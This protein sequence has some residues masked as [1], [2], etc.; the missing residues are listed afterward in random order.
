MRVIN[1]DTILKNGK[2]FAQT[3]SD[4]INSKKENPLSFE[5][6]FGDLSDCVFEGSLLDLDNTKIN[7]LKGC[8]KKI[9]GWL[10]LWNLPLLKSLDFFPKEISLGKNIFVDLHHIPEMRRFS[11]EALKGAGEIYINATGVNFNYNRNFLIDLAS[12][13]LEFR[14]SKGSY[15][16]IF[17]VH[18]D[19][20]NDVK[21]HL[22]LDL[23]RMESVYELYEK[24]GFNQIK[25]E[26]ALKLL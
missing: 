17:V 4:R 8:P 21:E 6:V 11:F 1:E 9:E 2:T 14:R 13:F 18:L 25:L 20:N 5:G 3:L 22:S 15:H 10:S 19:H 26:R 12:S 16:N 23:D 24:V 7:S